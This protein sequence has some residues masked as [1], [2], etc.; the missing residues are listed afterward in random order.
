MK[1][2]AL[3]DGFCGGIRRREGEVFDFAGEK[4]AKWMKPVEAEDAPQPEKPV[5]A[6][7]ATLSGIARRGHAVE[8]E[9]IRRKSAKA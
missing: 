3:T 7:D 5:E 6:E 2:R 4:P 9:G 8:M 1:V